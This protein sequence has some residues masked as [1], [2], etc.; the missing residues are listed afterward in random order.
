[1]KNDLRF[2][3]WP[4]IFD[5]CN[6]ISCWE[7]SLNAINPIISKYTPTNKPNSIKKGSIWMNKD[8]ISKLKLKNTSAHCYLKNKR[9]ARLWNICI[10]HKSIKRDMEKIHSR[11]KKG[12][13][14]L[15]LKHLLN[16]HLRSWIIH[17]PLLI[18][19][20]AINL[21]IIIVKNKNIWYVFHK[22]IYERMR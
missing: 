14:K 9:S 2:I 22:R 4:Q 20:I 19:K 16:M 10:V 3:N 21:L 8:A 7:K 12:W 5:S 13:C 6:T 15:I 18:W 11:V 1:M 17:E